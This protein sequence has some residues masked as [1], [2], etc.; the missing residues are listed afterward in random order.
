MTAGIGLMYIMSDVIQ[1]VDVEE[2]QSAFTD[3]IH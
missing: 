2:A 1:E 3:Q